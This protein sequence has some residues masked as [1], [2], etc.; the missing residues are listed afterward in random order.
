MF[1]SQFKE[2]FRLSVLV[3]S[4]T[5]YS[6]S[7]IHVDQLLQLDQEVQ[8]D[9]PQFHLSRQLAPVDQ[10]IQVDLGFP[11]PLSV[12]QILSSAQDLQM[13]TLSQ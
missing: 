6:N 4:R 5:R 1:Y 13:V 8:V 2:L 11:S 10:E 7:L 3:Y 12:Q 9:L